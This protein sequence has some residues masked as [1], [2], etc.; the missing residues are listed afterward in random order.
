[1]L[2]REYGQTG[3]KVSLLGFGGMRFANIDD[4]DECVRMMVTAAEG[5]VNYFDTAPAYFGIKSE[6]VFG[7]GFAELRR[8]GLPFYSATKTFASTEDKIRSEIEAQLKRLGLETI[9]FYHIWCIT[10]LNEWQE[11][12]KNNVLQTFRKLKKEGLI[13]HICVSSH[14]IND[15]IKDLLLED[16]FE[17]VLLGYSAYNFRTRQAAFDA[18]REK[19]LGTVVMNPLGGGIIPKHKERFGFLRRPGEEITAAAL[20]FIWDHPEVSVNLVGFETIEQVREALDAMKAY[21]PRTETELAAVKA[22]AP[23]SLEGLCTGCAYCMGSGA[24]ALCPKGIPISQLMEAYNHKI[25]AKTEK[26]DPIK[27]R[28]YWHWDLERSDASGCT[29]CGL[30]EKACTQHI[31][32]IERLKEIAGCDRS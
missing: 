32:I 28:L 21:K 18:I 7:K 20:S 14:L 31:N 11:R 25:L 16:V 9:D 24:G 10:S 27:D 26:G 12:K 5:G 17:G 6:T 30:C 4:H 19:K 3:K 2:Y 8:R 1:M 22:N 13:R 29:A 23:A 15:E